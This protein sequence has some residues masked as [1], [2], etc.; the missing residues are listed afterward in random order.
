MNEF[1]GD[2]LSAG[3][4]ARP[5]CA[6]GLLALL[7][8]PAW[9]STV[10]DVYITLV[11]AR[12]WAERGA[13]EWS[14]GERVEGYSNFLF[15]SLMAASAR[16]G[17]DIDLLAQVVAFASACAIVVLLARGLPRTQA[18]TL[19]LAAVVT[20]APLAHWSMI[21]METTFY[22]LLLVLGWRW[23]FGTPTRWGLGIV[24]LSAAS[25]TRPEGALHLLIAL[26]LGLYF[27]Q[28][29]RDRVTAAAVIA[30]LVAYHAIRTSWFGHFVPTSYLVKV[31]SHGLTR[32]GA[33]Q[34]FGDLLTAIGIGVALPAAGRVGGRGALFALLP[35]AI[36]GATLTRA[37]GDWMSWGRITLPGMLASVAVFSS[38]AVWR[39]RIHPFVLTAT[40]IAVLCGS[41]LVPRGNGSVDLHFRD[42]RAVARSFGHFRHGLDT[43]VA[44]DVAWVVDNAPL[45]EDGLV[46]DAGMLGDIPGFGL[47]DIRGLNN[48]SAAEAAARGRSG[49]WNLALLGDADARPGFV[50]FANWAGT[51]HGALPAW[52]VGP[53]E[54]RVDLRYG[55]GSIRWYATSGQVPTAAQ[56][57]ERWIELLR[58]HPSHPFLAWHAALSAAN[59]GDLDRAM[60]LARKAARRWPS[61]AEF[62]DAPASLSFTQSA[63]A[64]TWVRDA[65]F[66]IIGDNSSFSRM[67]AP[68]EVATLI[69]TA[70]RPDLRLAVTDPCDPTVTSLEL[71]VPGSLALRPCPT[72]RRISVR[73]A[74]AKEPMFVHIAEP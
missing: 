39:T 65:G 7:A 35:L 27:K 61:M 11:Y 17:L 10:D 34:L 21:G 6:L 14:T 66:K 45:G 5:L 52:L 56:R 70:S 64:L 67:I 58:R 69:A 36:Q 4:L 26:L 19:V 23:V 28:G 12:N 60:D 63:T 48:R 33:I 42:L 43:P 59:T 20:W 41:L 29:R 13:L 74:S 3:R 62:A 37:S 49:E 1:E 71:L 47:I 25:I 53:Y 8:A 15:M 38:V 24:S 18:G 46:V 2:R 72:A 32:H 68:A 54:L 30:T 9:P 31:A 51:E 22:A 73:S 55:G 57:E 40:T 44:E 50:R 16:L